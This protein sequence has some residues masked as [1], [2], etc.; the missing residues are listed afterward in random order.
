MKI[1]RLFVLMPLLFSCGAS[2]SVNPD[3]YFDGFEAAAKAQC[4]GDSL[5]FVCNSGLVDT[6]FLYLEDDKEEPTDLGVKLS[7]LNLDMRLSGLKSNSI[8]EVKASVQTKS[9]SGTGSRIYITGVDLPSVVKLSDGGIALSPNFYLD[10]G[11]LYLDFADAAVINVALKTLNEDYKDF[12]LRGYSDLTDDQKASINEELPLSTYFP[13]AIE[14]MKRELNS[15]YAASPEGFTFAQKD[16]A[17]SI[18]YSTTSWASLRKIVDSFLNEQESSASTPLD[19]LELSS[20]LDEAETKSRIDKFNLSMTFEETKV[21]H[22][23]LDLSFTFLEV[24]E[25][26][27]FA[28]KGTWTIKGSVEMGNLSPATLST[29]DKNRYTEIDW[30]ERQP[31]TQE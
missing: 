26:A 30:P 19:S 8:D 7:P 17:K 23:D 21:N 25:T 31:E 10:T 28:P 14:A 3:E 27:S 24:D 6:H 4:S 11:R 15:S 9:A 29:R 1:K 16:A 5:S 12:P 18:T 20:F 13:K 2:S 22:I